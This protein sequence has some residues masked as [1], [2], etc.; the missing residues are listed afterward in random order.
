MTTG[1]Y[2]LT[3]YLPMRSS[4]TPDLGLLGPARSGPCLLRKPPF[5]QSPHTLLPLCTPRPRAV[6]IN[7]TVSQPPSCC[8]SYCFF[9]ACLLSPRWPCGPQHKH[10]LLQEG[11]HDA[12]ASISTAPQYT[13]QHHHR[14]PSMSSPL[15]CGLT[16]VS[17]GPS[18]VAGTQ[19]KDRA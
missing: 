6:H 5:V 12:F 7:S 13:T 2:L 11:F 18:V 14:I 8:S 3:T 17:T 19:I 10:H 15:A 9:P 16:S 4:Q 1:P